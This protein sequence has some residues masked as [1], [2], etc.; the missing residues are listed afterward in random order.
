MKITVNRGVV[1]AD[2]CHDIL[3]SSFIRFLVRKKPSIFD[4][5]G[6]KKSESGYESTIHA[7]FD[8]GKY[9]TNEIKPIV[10]AF[11]KEWLRSDSYLRAGLAKSQLAERGWTKMAIEKWL[12]SCDIEVDN[13][14]YKS[15]APMQIYSINRVLRAESREDWQEWLTKRTKK[16]KPMKIMTFRTEM[17][18]DN[19]RV[20]ALLGSLGVK[21]K[22]QKEISDVYMPDYKMGLF[23][24]EVPDNYS[25]DEFR[26][27]MEATI[28]SNP[29]F[30]NMHRCFQTLKEG[31]EPDEE[32]YIRN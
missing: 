25:V 13:P 6:D 20:P 18:G 7:T 1:R 24:I 17:S 32:W 28:D 8:S 10:S 29:Q 2:N 22:E 14:H 11:K 19:E 27:F 15:G 23:T 26:A 31:L 4:W 16:N 21:L 12:G 3:R 9:T 30:V 5:K